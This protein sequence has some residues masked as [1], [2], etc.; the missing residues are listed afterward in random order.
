MKR[1]SGIVSKVILAILLC[2]AV[3]VMTVCFLMAAARP[4][5]TYT[6]KHEFDCLTKAKKNPLVECKQ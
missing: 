6:Q 3:S 2:L 4:K 5:S 1:N